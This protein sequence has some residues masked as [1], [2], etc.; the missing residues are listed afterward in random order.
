MLLFSKKIKDGKKNTFSASFPSHTIFSRSLKFPH[1]HS[2]YSADNMNVNSSELTLAIPAGTPSPR[3]SRQ[4]TMSDICPPSV[5][6]LLKA[7]L[8]R[9]I[10]VSFTVKKRTTHI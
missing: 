8:D 6:T 5:A 3:T 9:F 7:S 10:S 4:K 2:Y 1:F